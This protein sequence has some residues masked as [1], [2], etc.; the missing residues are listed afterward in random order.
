MTGKIKIF[1]G[2]EDIY[3]DFICVDDIV[4]IVPNNRCGSG[5]YDMGSNHSYSF[6]DIAE[7]I[8]KNTGRRSLRSPSPNI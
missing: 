3:R 8:A 4:R 6:R 7:I 2:S 5:I 1:E